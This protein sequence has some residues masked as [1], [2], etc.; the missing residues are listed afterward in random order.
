METAMNRKERRKE[1]FKQKDSAEL[2]EEL[3]KMMHRIRTAICTDPDDEC[4]K[5]DYIRYIQW[6][7]EKSRNILS[8]VLHDCEAF[9]RQIDRHA[10]GDALGAINEVE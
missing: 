10:I 2:R 5:Y 9:C 3:I 8:K 6:N 1:K 4:R 7:M